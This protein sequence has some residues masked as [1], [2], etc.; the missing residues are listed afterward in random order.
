MTI[1]P[2]LGLGLGR[3]T[4]S[5]LDGC[6][7]QPPCDPTTSMCM[8]PPPCGQNDPEIMNAIKIGDGFSRST[9]TPRTSAALR[10]AVPLFEHVWFDAIAA[11]TVA[12]FGHTDEYKLPPGTPLPYQVPPEDLAL[13]GEPRG[14][15]QLGFGLRV[16]AP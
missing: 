3:L 16:G 10:I 5:R 7:T 12:P 8:Q 2:E 1:A 4:T 13:P 15:L 11:V 14:T 9:I 6:R